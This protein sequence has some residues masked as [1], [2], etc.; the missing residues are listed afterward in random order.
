MSLEREYQINPIVPESVMHNT[1]V[2]RRVYIQAVM[3][4]R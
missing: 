2:R 1:R 3:S 4:H